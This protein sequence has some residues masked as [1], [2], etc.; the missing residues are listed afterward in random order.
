VNPNS[1]GEG[2]SGSPIA[3]THCRV[4]PV[5]AG[6]FDELC[7]FWTRNRSE[8]YPHVVMPDSVTAWQACQQDAGMRWFTSRLGPTLAAAAVLARISGPPWCSAEVGVGVDARLRCHGIGARTLRA[9]FT[10]ELGAGLARIEALV[11]P[12]NIASASMVAAAGMINEGI[13]RSVLDMGG[14][15]KDM[16]RWAIV[17]PHAVPGAVV[18]GST[19]ADN[20]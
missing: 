14:T 9:I 15:R 6:D 3:P 7:S 17:A 8:L 4:R 16:S 20:P 13:S 2:P 11:D 1:V 12:D 19:T 18:V 10:R 5:T